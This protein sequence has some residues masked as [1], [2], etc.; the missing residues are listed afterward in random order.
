MTKWL[1]AALVLGALFVAARLAVPRVSSSVAQGPIDRD[2]E[3]RLADC[4]DSPNCQGSDSSREGQRVAPFPTRGTP[5]ETI[6]ALAALI[7]RHDGAAVIAREPGYLHATFTSSLMGYVDDVEFLVDER[8]DTVRVRSASRIGRSD[9]GANA[10]RVGGASRG[11][12]GPRPA[13][14]RSGRGGVGGPGAGFPS[15]RASRRAPRW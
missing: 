1:I 8:S 4:P 10:K 15:D 9:L 3:R 12:D 11:V 7:E 13:R 2:G 5:A 6:A 14:T